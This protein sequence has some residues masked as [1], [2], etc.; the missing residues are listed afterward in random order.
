MRYIGEKACSLFWDFPAG[1]SFG[2]T[3]FSAIRGH[4]DYVTNGSG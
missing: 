2:V 1:V 3:F 4:G